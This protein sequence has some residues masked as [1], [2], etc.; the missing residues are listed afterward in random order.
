MMQRSI[1]V[2]LVLILS[3]FVD[4]APYPTP[5]SGDFIIKNFRFKSGEV[6]PELRLHYRTLGRPV[7][8]AKGRVN[9]AVLILHGTGGNGA[10][11]LTDHFAGVLFEPGQVLDANRYFIILPDGIGHGGSSKPS[12]GLHARFPHYTY[13]D[14]VEAQYRLLSEKLGVDHLRLVLGTSMGGMHT[15]LW[16]EQHPAFM[17][18]LMPLA[19]LPVEIAGRNRMQRRMIM[20]S[21]RSDPGWKN[22]EYTTQP[23]G[24][25]AAVHIEVI[26]TSSPLQMQK[27]APTR[28]ETDTLLDELVK[29]RLA[30]TDANDLL[31]Q[32]DA[33][34]EYNPAL[35]LQKIVAPLLAINSADDEI[36]PPELGIMEQEIKRVKRGRVVL[37][38][39][40]DETR[41]H[42][43]HS[44]PAIW[45]NHLAELLKESGQ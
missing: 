2:S 31:Y 16:G 42:G 22:G 32:Y 25:I 41:G 12:D 21:I 30:R 8:D 1:V 45:Q 28:S 3:T 10:S 18:A 26:E 37:L 17:D 7:R 11:F 36:N 14:M 35:G 23:R 39:V 6:L 38:P 13:D 33:S 34:R 29:S 9:N 4:A 20:D 5:L 43:T 15:W 40:S 44:Y 27:N 19:C 24:L